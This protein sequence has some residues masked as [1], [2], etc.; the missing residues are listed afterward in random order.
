MQR[1]QTAL[2]HAEKLAFGKISPL[3][4]GSSRRPDRMS[5]RAGSGYTSVT[6]SSPLENSARSAPTGS[7][8]K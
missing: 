8:V 4:A 5:G 2:P 3:R 6:A 7:S 1:F